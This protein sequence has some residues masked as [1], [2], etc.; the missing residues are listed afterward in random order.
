MAAICR[1]L[2]GLP[3]AIELAAARIGHL[4]PAAL[5]ARLARRLPL[6]TG[7]PRDAP[8]RLRT[9]R[10]AIA[11]SYDLLDAR[12]AGPLPP[13]RRLRRRLHPGGGRGGSESRSRGVEESRRSA[14]RLLD[15]STPDSSTT[16]D[17]LGSLIDHSLVRQ[18]EGP[19]GQ[20]G[21]SR[22]GMLETIREFGLEQLAASGEEPRARDTHAAFFAGLVAQAA[23]ALGR[24]GAPE[25]VA[26]RLRLAADEANL[27]SALTWLL[28]RPD[29]DVALRMAGGLGWYWFLRGQLREGRDWLE[30]ALAAGQDGSPAARALVQERAAWLAW[31][32]GDAPAAMGHA[33]PA[34]QTYRSLGDGAGIAQALHVLGLATQHAGDHDRAEELF[35]EAFAAYRAVGDAATAG[36]TLGELAASRWAVGDLAAAETL[37]AEGLDLIRTT[38]EPLTAAPLLNSRGGIARRT[39]GP[40]ARGDR[41]R[42]E[43][44][45]LAGARLGARTAGLLRGNRDDRGGARRC[46]IRGA[47][48]RDRRGPPRSHRQ[49]GDAPRSRSVRAGNCRGAGY[50]V[51]VSI[52]HG[53]GRRAGA[54]ARPG[55]GRGRSGARHGRFTAAGQTGRG[56]RPDRRRRGGRADGARGRRAALAGRRGSPTPRSPR[57]CSSAEAPYAPTFPT[58][59]ASSAPAP[60][61]RPPTPPTAWVSSEPDW[62]VAYHQSVPVEPG[63]PRPPPGRLSIS[64]RAGAAAGKEAPDG[65]GGRCRPGRRAARRPI[66][67]RGRRPRPAGSGPWPAPAAA[68]DAAGR[69]GAGAGRGLPPAAASGVRLVTL[70]GPGGVG[71]TRLALRGRRRRSPTA[72]ADG[73]AFVAAGPGRAI[74]PSSLPAD[75]RARSACASAGEPAARRPRWRRVPA[76]P[77]RCCWCSTTSSRWSRRRRALAELLA[78]CPGLTVLATSR[79]AAAPLRRARRRRSPPLALARAP[80]RGAPLDEVGR[81]RRRSR[82]FVARARA[83][84]PDFALTAGQRRRPSPRSAAGWTGCRWRSSWRR[85]GSASRRRP[86]CWPGW[87]G[88]LPLLTGGPRDAPARQRTMRDAIAWSL[89]P[90]RR[91][92]SRRSSAGWRSSPAASRWRRPRRSAGV[93][94]SRRRDEPTSSRRSTLAPRWSTSSLL[95]ASSRGRLD[96]RAAL[97]DA[98]DGPRVRAGAAGAAGET[99][100]A[101]R[102]HAA[103]FLAL[104]E[105]AARRAL[106]GASSRAVAGSTARPSTTTCGRRWTGVERPASGAR[107]CAWPAR[108]ERLVVLPGP[109]RAKGSAG[110][111]WRSVSPSRG[112]TA[113]AGLDPEGHALLAQVRGDVDLAVARYAE[114]IRWWQTAGDPRG[115]VVTRSFLGGA[116]SARGATTRRPRSSRTTCAGFAS[117]GRRLDRPRPLPPRLDRL[118]P[119]R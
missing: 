91:R 62:R 15:S 8:P 75:R 108:S 80:I 98:G 73:V 56:R 44:G 58:S 89:R 35:R 93:E 119:R 47:A 117:G 104:A 18:E 109:S 48:L 82:L 95:S 81:H 53:V 63:R 84:R 30:R 107:R 96:G 65:S 6:L 50:A 20:G 10:D 36:A 116:L 38:D 83:A 111:T 46:E 100:A 110:P 23:T 2:D 17:R 112:A 25:E 67:T 27:R 45:G 103:H 88:R 61:P 94:E 37:I 28:E 11:W 71:K 41:L 87:S 74:P 21:G 97:R 5:L 106:T 14:I 33:D 9:M 19:A 13:P 16:L 102:R 40:D 69:A 55:A 101:R 76:R 113:A 70:T 54:P 72:F 92:R 79:A 34:L 32:H 7:G 90:A 105:R 66:Q 22:F 78:A 42:R 99:E 39:R 57:P 85:R 49:A 114:A 118:R 29:G 51:R 77:A 68:A 59:S 43:F 60:A 64:G 86:R 3:L 26:W 4:T 12:G 31:D 1:R 52:R 24:F 115:R